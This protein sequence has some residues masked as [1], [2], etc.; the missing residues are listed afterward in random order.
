MDT[1]KTNGHDNHDSVNILEP[2]IYDVC[3]ECEEQLVENGIKCEM[4]F[5]I[6]Q[7]DQRKLGRKFFS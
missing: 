7:V 6:N 4:L 5:S 3:V 2:S 1:A